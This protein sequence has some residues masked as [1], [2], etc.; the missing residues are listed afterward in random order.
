MGGRKGIGGKLA[1]EQGERNDLKRAIVGECDTASG[2]HEG[3][4]GEQGDREFLKGPRHLP[5]EDWEV[6]QSGDR[7]YSLCK[8]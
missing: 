1:G 4:Y 5:L 8:S 2:A 7:P 3:K 6:K